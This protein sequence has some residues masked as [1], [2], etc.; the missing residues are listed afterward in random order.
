MSLQK[1]FTNPNYKLAS[2]HRSY[3]ELPVLLSIK[4]WKDMSK[5][6]DKLALDKTLSY[7]RGHKSVF[8]LF[9]ENGELLGEKN[10]TISYSIKMLSGSERNLVLI[11]KMSFLRLRFETSPNET[12][13][14]KSCNGMRSQG[15]AMKKKCIRNKGNYESSFNLVGQ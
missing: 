8:R 13:R 4:G 6:W 9:A 3:V 5:R 10:K 7:Y 1:K 2:L 14:W 11:T 15:V 12:D